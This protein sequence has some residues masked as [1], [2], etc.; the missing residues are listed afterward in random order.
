MKTALSS[1]QPQT[2]KFQLTHHGSIHWSDAWHHHLVSTARPPSISRSL[3]W[4]PV[5]DGDAGLGSV[6]LLHPIDSDR[7]PMSESRREKGIIVLIFGRKGEV[8]FWSTNDNDNVRNHHGPQ[9]GV[10]I[11]CEKIQ[12]HS[13]IFFVFLWSINQLLHKRTITVLDAGIINVCKILQS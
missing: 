11:R 10:P 5:S 13:S 8:F 4:V 9:P 3:R 12:W 6:S 1:A 2:W 7:D